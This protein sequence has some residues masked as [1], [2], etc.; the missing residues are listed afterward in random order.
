MSFDYFVSRLHKDEAMGSEFILPPHTIH[1]Y[2]FGSKLGLHIVVTTFMSTRT[3]TSG[4]VGTNTGW[5]LSHSSQIQ[6]VSGGMWYKHGKFRACSNARF[7]VCVS[8]RLAPVNHL[9]M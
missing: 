1:C 3:E 8:C 5:G 7:Y 2:C 9:G 4:V 6:T